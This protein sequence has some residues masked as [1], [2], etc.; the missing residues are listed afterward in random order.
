[1]DC[2]SLIFSKQHSPLLLCMESLLILIIHQLDSPTP[3]DRDKLPGVLPYTASVPHQ[4][5]HLRRFS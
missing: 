2:L 4:F 1:M 5:C 3:K